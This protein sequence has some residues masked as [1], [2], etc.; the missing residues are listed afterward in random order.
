MKKIE[1]SLLREGGHGVCWNTINEVGKSELSLDDFLS[2]L[3]LVDSLLE[4][5]W[6]FIEEKE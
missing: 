5:F 3:A 6:V 1:L 4:L 2:L